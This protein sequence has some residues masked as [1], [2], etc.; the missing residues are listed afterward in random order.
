[1]DP[2]KIEYVSLPDPFIVTVPHELTSEHFTDPAMVARIKAI[3]LAQ[4][5]RARKDRGQTYS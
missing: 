5:E 4:I 3:Q 1:M 2:K